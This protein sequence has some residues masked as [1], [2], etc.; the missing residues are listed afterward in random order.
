MIYTDNF[1]ICSRR[2]QEGRVRQRPS[3]RV[4]L[5]RRVSCHVR[6][7]ECED[8]HG[9][10]SLQDTSYLENVIEI[11]WERANE[12]GVHDMSMPAIMC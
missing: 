4:P 9:V 3:A 10:S 6:G 8:A 1:F 2:Q 11:N 7:D 12:S 5:G